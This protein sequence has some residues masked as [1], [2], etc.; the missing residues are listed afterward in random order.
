MDLLNNVLM[1]F[2]VALEPYNL[3]WAAFGVF[4]GNLIGVLPGLGVLASISILLPLTYTMTPTA[5]LMMLAGIYYGSQYGGGIT[6]IMLNMPGT[7]SHAVACLDGNPMARTGR[8]GSALFMLMFSSFCGA[9]V[10]ILTMMLFSPMLTEVA[11]QFGPAEYFAMMTVGLLAGS[12]LAKGSAIKG[13]AM[14]VLG[15]ILGVVGTDV[16]SGMMRFTFGVPELSDGLAL[17]AVAMGFFGVA[18]ILANVNRVGSGT[19]IKEAGKI[20]MRALRPQKGDIRQSRSALVRGTAIGAAFGIL[21]GTGP[22]IAS[23]MSYAVEKK[24]AKDPR[25]FGR[26]AIEGVASPEAATSSATQTSFIPTM[27]LGI[28]GDPVMALMLGALIIHGIQPGPQ[29]L[30][31]H[32]D[33]FWGLIASFWVGNIILLI[34]NLPL[35]GMWVRLLS[36]Q[37]RYLYPAALFF[38]CVGVYSTNNNLFDVWVVM[39]FGVVGY[40]FLRL[41][42]EAAP[43]LLGFVLGPLVEENFRR[44]LLLSRGDMSIFITRPISAGFVAAGL[45]LILALAWSYFKGRRKAQYE[46]TAESGS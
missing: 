28:P 12:T 10:G 36:V 39:I 15:L 32:A 19:T 16:N 43:L 23:F 37:Y 44:A 17:V 13:V 38:L 6:S 25:R 27:S 21:P 8:A 41:R 40:L 18:D 35:I 5:A 45:A 30:T 1:G 33:I 20:S 26:G 4:M 9:T 29:L 3:M 7:A 2:G 11:F 14:V 31:E 24:V 46:I 42:F 34:L 22:T